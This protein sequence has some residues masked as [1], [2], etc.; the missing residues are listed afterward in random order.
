[1]ELGHS[2]LSNRLL[3]RGRAVAL[4]SRPAVRRESLIQH[5]HLRIPI[6]LGQHA[7]CSDR[8]AGHVALDLSAH[9]RC[10]KP[11]GIVEQGVAREPIVT[12]V[13]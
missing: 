1:M 3:M 9:W 10:A 2:E 7:R 8:R 13:E 11:R 12:P 6:D 5:R 4:V